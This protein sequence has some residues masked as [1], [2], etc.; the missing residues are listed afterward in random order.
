MTVKT[1]Q[2]GNDASV[3]I[4]MERVVG[5]IAA[6]TKTHGVITADANELGDAV[7]S[8]STHATAQQRT[9]LSK[10]LNAI[11]KAYSIGGMDWSSFRTILRKQT[12]A[13]GIALDVYP[14]RGALPGS[15]YPV[16]KIKLTGIVQDETPPI[17]SEPVDHSQSGN[18]ATVTATASHGVELA[19]EQLESLVKSKE[20]TAA[21]LMVLV[22]SM[23][24]VSE[25]DETM[26]EIGYVS[27]DKAQS[28]ME[29]ALQTERKQVK[30]EA[31]A[32]KRRA[33]AAKKRAAKK[34]A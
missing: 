6:H 15:R 8:A 10:L 18:Q 13:K 20:V 29:T 16:D 22:A 30:S 23:L 17:E 24:P 33:T 31:A 25:L 27:S 26:L 12:S 28:D 7:V 34:T 21:Q 11:D 2:L 5:D 9:D 1:L 14:V 3:S 19:K 32:A 4:Y